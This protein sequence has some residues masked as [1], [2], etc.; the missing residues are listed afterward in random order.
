MALVVTLSHLQK[1][2]ENRKVFTL[3]PVFNGLFV[4]P[5]KRLAGMKAS[6]AKA[7]FTGLAA[8]LLHAV[9]TDSP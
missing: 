7:A 3:L 4:F 9:P 2:A 6:T 8:W 1:L 5:K